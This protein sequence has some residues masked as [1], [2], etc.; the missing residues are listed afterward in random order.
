MIETRSTVYIE[1]QPETLV[2]IF[3]LVAAIM[4]LWLLIKTIKG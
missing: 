4:L 2:R 3:I 1:V